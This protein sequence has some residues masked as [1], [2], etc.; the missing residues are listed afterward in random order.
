MIQYPNDICITTSDQR[1]EKVKEKL[2]HAI[3]KFIDW[4]NLNVL[5]YRQKNRRPC[6][7]Q[8]VERVIYQ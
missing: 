6:S 2:P 8:D 4:M 5:C 1:I 7:L 3:L